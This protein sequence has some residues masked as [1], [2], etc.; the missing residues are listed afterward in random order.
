[1]LFSISHS[2]GGGPENSDDRLDDIQ[3]TPE[4][5]QT[6][7]QAYNLIQLAHQYSSVSRS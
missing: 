6:Q 2:G 4:Y 1:L 7:D 5:G 3:P